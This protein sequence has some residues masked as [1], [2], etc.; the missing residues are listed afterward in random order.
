M[1][2]VH[3]SI[4]EMCDANGRHMNLY[5]TLQKHHIHFTRVDHAAVYTCEEADQLL[6]DLPGA[7]T[8]NLFLRDRKG[9]RHFLV[10]V[11]GTKSVDL[12]ALAKM[13]E[14]NSLGFASP[15][16]L[17]KHLQLTPGSVSVL[18][19]LNDQARAVELVIDQPVWEA[20]SVQCHPLVNT[21]TLVLPIVD[22]QRLLNELERPVTVVEIPE[23]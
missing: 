9:K 2:S 21:T 5:N 12:K 4:I 3:R 22:L 8:K 11:S 1:K 19:I 14:V 20:E 18:A 23:K 6:P 15:E 17:Q 13:L 7:K 10:V 16:R